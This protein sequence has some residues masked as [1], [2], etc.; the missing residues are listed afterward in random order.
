MKTP[1]PDLIARLEAATGPDRELDAEIVAYLCERDRD[2]II[3][4]GCRIGYSDF[5]AAGAFPYYTESIDAA[6]TLVGDMLWMVNSDRIAWI[7]GEDGKTRGYGAGAN[8][9]I[10][11]C[12]AAL[13][14]RE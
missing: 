8:P 14:A 13:R 2:A 5:V 11:L 6:L 12:V 9:A 7:I 10:A 3:P 1:I 4:K